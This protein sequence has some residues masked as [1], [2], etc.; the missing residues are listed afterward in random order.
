MEY[1]SRAVENPATGEIV[2][3][4]VRIDSSG[5]EID[6]YTDQELLNMAL[7]NDMFSI[8]H[9]PEL[10]TTP[11]P[12]PTWAKQFTNFT[13]ENL[14]IPGGLV[15]AAVGTRGGPAGMIIGG[16]A[17]TFAGVIG[18]DYLTE[19]DISYADAMQEAGLSVGIDLATLMAGK[20][21]T[22]I[23]RP[24]IESGWLVAQRKLGKTPKESVE[25]LLRKTGE[26]TAEA[27]TKGSLF[28]SQRMLGEEGLTLLPSNVSEKNN[29]IQAIA[30]LGLFSSPIM[31]KSA[32]D[33]NNF[34]QQN[35][36]DIVNKG[37]VVGD[38]S[39][40]GETVYDL[41]DVA[42]KS[43][44][45]NYE[46]TM[47]NVVLPKLKKRGPIDVTGIKNKLDFTINNSMIPGVKS[48]SELDD[49]TLSFLGQ[50]RE[51]LAETKSLTPEALF[52]LEKKI[53]AQVNKL[54]E[55]GS[56]QFND[57]AAR[58]LFQFSTAIKDEFG[59][60][61][62]KVDPD[63]AAEYA[64]VKK[65]YAKGMQGILPELNA[66]FVRRAKKEDFS[67]LGNMVAGNG[68]IDQVRKMFSSIDK[69]YA[70]MSKESR[71]ELPYKTAKEAKQAIRGRYLENIFDDLSSDVFDIGKHRTKIKNL[72]KKGGDR[73]A[74][75]ILGEDYARARQVFNLIQEAG[76]KERSTI[77]T[78]FLKAK[79]FTA[80]TNLTAG[81]AVMGGLMGAGAAPTASGIGG[82]VAILTAPV[83][84]AAVAKSPKYVNKLVMLDNKKFGT[85]ALA[86][87]AVAN[88]IT[89]V[90]LT[91]SEEEQA[92]LKNIEKGVAQ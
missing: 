85:P 27:G 6:E 62:A 25:E 51:S 92:E 35:I 45:Q 53:T 32:D 8:I 80:I 49:A 63:A 23:L 87:A 66:S 71:A 69:A 79:E 37:F 78:L 7:E 70:T 83:F 2:S 40:L 17:G 60:A 19:E 86:A 10:T 89:D 31:S 41:L 29:M 57:T 55:R 48:M 73:K 58:E 18:S 11:K 50:L 67:A 68:S 36:T 54:G 28:A 43:L 9:T 22:R 65:A 61:L 30:E 84:L 46:T 1:K 14:D 88:F 47:N 33:I 82:A 21:Y 4:D 26:G 34:V 44:S 42:R 38:P 72:L 3:I 90:M 39:Q 64:K 24:L 77:G 12:E 59:A 91:M 13:K 56:A 52:A 16:A 75:T 81:A 5:K 76:T 15:G 74:Q 20:A